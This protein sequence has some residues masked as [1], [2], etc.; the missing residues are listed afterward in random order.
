MTRLL[1]LAKQASN[2]RLTR[3]SRIVLSDSAGEAHGDASFRANA[4]VAVGADDPR[5]FTTL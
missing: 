3:R 2:K 5:G 4:V 1:G